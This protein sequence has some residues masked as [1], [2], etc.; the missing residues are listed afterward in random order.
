M[1]EALTNPEN[2]VV[3]LK[4]MV[5]P[6]LEHPLAC[7]MKKGFLAVYLC[8]CSLLKYLNIF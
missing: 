5:V 6:Y 1:H 3:S 7:L 4:N 2:N 8:K